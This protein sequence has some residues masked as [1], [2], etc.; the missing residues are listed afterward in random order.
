MRTRFSRKGVQA[1]TMVEAL[2]VVAVLVL[3][4]AALLPSLAD[5][6]SRSRR[7]CCNCNLKQVG[8]AFRIWAGDHGNKYPTQVS[9]TN[10]GTM[11]FVGGPNAWMHF[12]VMSNELNTAKIL[13]CPSDRDSF[14]KAAATFPTFTG[15]TS[16][17]YFVGVDAEDREPQRFL[18]GDRNLTNGTAITRGMLTLTTNRLS[19]WT[20]EMHGHQGNVG[21]AD[22][23]VQGF[24]TASLRIALESTG[25]ETNRLAM[26]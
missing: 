20:A 16:L 6:Y 19:G 2:M 13:F 17:N 23:S 12:L 7:I 25:L 1:L 11:E 24:S 26:P 10:G 21:L 15:N 14:R 3:L 18:T 4:A 9:I 22:G 8:I 5:Q